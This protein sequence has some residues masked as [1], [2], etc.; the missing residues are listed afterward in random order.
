[1]TWK[2]TDGGKTFTGVPRRAG[3]RRLPAHLDQ[4]RPP[5]L[6]ILLASDQGAIITVNGGETWSSWY[7]QPTA[8]FYHVSTDNAFPYRVC[9]GQQESGSACVAEPRRRRPDHVPRLAPGRRR[10]VRLR[11]ARP[12]RSRHRLRRQGD[13][14]RPAHRPGAERRRRTPCAARD[15]RVVRTAPVLFS[16]IDPQSP[17]LRLEHG[18]ED[19]E[20]RAALGGDQP[21]PDARRTWAV[22][23]RTSGSTGQTPAAAGPSAASSTPSRRRRS[24]QTSSGP[25]PTTA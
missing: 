5:G 2:S 12:A 23:G 21:R 14:L 6:I 17:V 11:R 8:Q 20:R 13:A 1:M 15:Y 4:P 10:G 22:P 19:D 3:R 18:L 25:A 24:T 16:P 7:N 9:G